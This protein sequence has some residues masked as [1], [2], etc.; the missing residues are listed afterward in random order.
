MLD[1]KAVAADF[2]T[3]ERRLARRGE[4]AA[5]ALAPVRPLALRRRELNLQIEKQKKEQSEANAKI[6]ELAKTDKGAVEGARAQLR[7]L[8]DEVKKSE[9]ELGQVEAE[10]ERLLLLVPNPPSDTVPDGKDEKD[11][12]IV[13]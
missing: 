13:R 4:K 5:Q 3:F 10:I 6:R 1:L 11:N 7:A 12:V 8:G 9:Q 2:D